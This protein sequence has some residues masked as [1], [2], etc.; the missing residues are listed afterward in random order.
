VAVAGIIGGAK[1]VKIVLFRRQIV[2]SQGNYW[3]VK[4]IFIILMFESGY[5]YI[6]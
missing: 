6:N 2:K 5:G 4:F 1:I 3:G